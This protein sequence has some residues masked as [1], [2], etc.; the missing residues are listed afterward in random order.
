MLL[1]HSFVEVDAEGSDISGT[2]GQTFYDYHLHSRSV[3]GF[4]RSP[5]A[6]KAGGISKPRLKPRPSI[7]R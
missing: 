4:A 1:L 5:Q 2:P 7:L 6:A 3:T